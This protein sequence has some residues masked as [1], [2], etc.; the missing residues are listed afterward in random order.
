MHLL[1]G[2]QSADMLDLRL[3]RL[4]RE[5]WAMKRLFVLTVMAAITIVAARS[6]ITP[7][8]IEARSFV[9]KD[10]G[11]EKAV[12]GPGQL[13][14]GEL[15]VYRGRDYV[16]VDPG[17]IDFGTMTPLGERWNPESEWTTMINRNFIVVATGV[18]STKINPGN[19]EVSAGG[20]NTVMG[21]SETVVRTSGEHKTS[22]GAS[23]QMFKGSDLIWRIP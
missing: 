11:I 20:F 1:P 18:G 21:Q 22:S 17:M 9:V 4:E 12:L 10:H 19:V 16:A 8:R 15:K 23:I 7:Q 5:N 14:G 2:S 13:S 6:F 3:R